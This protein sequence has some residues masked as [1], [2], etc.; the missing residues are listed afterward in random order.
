MSEPLLDIQQIKKL[1]PHRYPFL[2]LDRVLELEAGKYCKALKNVTGNEACF[3]GHF[4]NWPLF[5]GVLQIEAMAQACGLAAVVTY[6][7]ITGMLPL[8]VGIN[9]ARFKRQ[10]VPGV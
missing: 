6:D 10:V 1:L 8:F 9:K 2:M 4:P 5:P 7:D 3:Q